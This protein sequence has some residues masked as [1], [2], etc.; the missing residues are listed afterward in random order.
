VAPL[1]EKVPSG[2]NGGGE[3]ESGGDETP[4]SEA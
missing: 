4:V 3:P 2:D 1:A